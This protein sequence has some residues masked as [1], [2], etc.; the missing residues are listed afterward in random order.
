[1][2]L[3]ISS[4][5]I[6]LGV[7]SENLELLYTMKKPIRVQ[8]DDID[9]F[10]KSFDMDYLWNSIK[11]FLSI[12]IDKIQ[13]QNDTLIGI[14]TCAQRIATVF[15]DE[16][17]EIIY[18]GPNVDVRG[19]DSAYLI[20][21]VFTEERFFNITAHSPSIMF[22]LSRLLW[23][24]EER[25]DLYEKIG[26][27]LMLDDWIVYKLTG[28][29]VTDYTSI[30]ESQLFNIR[31][32]KW[33]TEIIEAFD[34]DRNILP[35]ITQSGQIIGDLKPDLK[36]KWDIKNQ[37]V[38]VIKS[39]GD[40]QAS[41]LGMGVINECDLGISLG[42]TAPLHL[43]LNKPIFDPNLNFWTTFHSIEGKYLLEANAGD[44]GTAYN[45]FL[46]AFL[47]EI[48]PQTYT[49]VEKHLNETQPGLSSLFTFLGPELMHFR[50]QSTISRGAFVF[51]P[52]TLIGDGLPTLKN[53]T[54]SVLENIG[55][56]IL[57]NFKAL[58]KFS[59]NDIKT[60]IGGG[61]AKSTAFSQ[62]LSNI[63][64]SQILSPKYKDTAFIGS[65]MN[66]LLGTKRYSDYRSII[67]NLIEFQVFEPNVSRVKKYDR[68]F[69]EWDNLK[70]KVDD[71]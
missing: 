56:G 66:V 26:K 22:S 32:K 31:K 60:Y 9:G 39:G 21:D 19:I 47:S 24:K 37:D 38:P 33:S 12:A 36:T 46:K 65:A 13:L 6:K 3:D 41:L 67:E 61:M 54:R 29:Q 43:V 25:K 34:I 20:D 55:F 2:T 52:P 62:M 28:K 14:S 17:G 7:L 57:L 68:I 30:G 71:L 27:I 40:T 5:N 63:L 45:W 4:A 44:T 49:I 50:D 51:E 58:K 35:K 64:N 15:L 8:N 10:A 69:H 1:M 11:E 59:D 53:F 18:G 42:T 70:N 16:T 23:F 48:S